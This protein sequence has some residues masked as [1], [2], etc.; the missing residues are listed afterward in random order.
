[1]AEGTRMLSFGTAAPSACGAQQPRTRRSASA[2]AVTRSKCRYKRW[3]KHPTFRTMATRAELAR[4]LMERSKPK[5][6]KSPPRPRRDVPVNTALPGVSATD[7]K[8]GAGNGA[9]NLKKNGTTSASFKLEA[10]NGRPSRKST[11]RSA[12][13]VKQNNNLTRRQ[14]R[15]VRSPEAIAARLV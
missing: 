8:A 7:R 1:M 12:N 10:S 11:R 14:K 9:R 6:P 4:Y 15:R 5:L 13:R 2:I 3:A